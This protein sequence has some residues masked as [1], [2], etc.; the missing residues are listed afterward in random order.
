MEWLSLVITIVVSILTAIATSFLTLGKY[1]EKVDRLEKDVDKMAVKVDALRS[2]TDKSMASIASLEK[3]IDKLTDVAQSHS[4]I[5]LTEKGKRLIRESGFN[6]IFENTKD[7]LVRDLEKLSPRSQYDVQEKA[8]MM[9]SSMLD[10]AR[11]RQVED[12]AYRNG[13]DF[14]QIMRAGSIKLRDYFFEKHPE[15]V[16][17]RERY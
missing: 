4:P 1:K 11:F 13:E 16:D 5:Q 8:R 12:W 17:P 9:L 7:E 10:D 6:D 15:I 3:S 14:A 2:D